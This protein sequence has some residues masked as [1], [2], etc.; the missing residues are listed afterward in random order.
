MYNL[1]EKYIN[2]MTLED[3]NNFALSKNITLSDSEIMFVYGFIKKNYQMIL[4]NPNN[5]DIDRYK[6]HFSE[7]NFPKVKK[8]ILEYYSKYKNYL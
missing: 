1:I 3:V 7:E 4:S 2:K 8:L 6:N 5:L